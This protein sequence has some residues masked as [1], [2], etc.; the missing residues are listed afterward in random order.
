M[1][2]WMYPICVW[3]FDEPMSL[4]TSRQRSLARRLRGLRSALSNRHCK[5]GP[6]R[7]SKCKSLLAH[8]FIRPNGSCDST[9]ESRWC[10]WIYEAGDWCS[11][12][13]SE[14]SGAS[15]R[16]S[17]CEERHCRC[18]PVPPPDHSLEVCP[19]VHRSTRRS[20]GA[21]AK[22]A[23]EGRSRRSNRHCAHSR[24]SYTSP[25]TRVPLVPLPRSRRS[26]G[27]SAWSVRWPTWAS[28]WTAR[29]SVL[30]GRRAGAAALEVMSGRWTRAAAFDWESGSRFPPRSTCAILTHAGFA[31]CLWMCQVKESLP[32]E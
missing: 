26:G 2:N 6:V 1:T 30:E 32:I 24:D 9:R 17:A 19:Y 8:H 18:P 7:D 31:T 11:S 25:P 12:P 3:P 23:T 27:A 15:K 28:D 4:V 14:S 22:A 29:A 13:L 21:G 16:R 5:S 10:S 20:E